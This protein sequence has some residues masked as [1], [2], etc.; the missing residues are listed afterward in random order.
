MK[1]S[2]KKNGSILTISLSG[3]LDE[4]HAE[5]A[6]KELDSI[7]QSG[8]NQTVVFDL[9]NLGFMDSTGIGILIG[10]YKYQRGRGVAFYVVNPSPTIDK[11]FKIA[12]LYEIMPLLD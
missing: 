8:N 10:R 12:G 9:K 2:Y 3:E 5:Y 6:R 1:I 7:L 11:I 4:C